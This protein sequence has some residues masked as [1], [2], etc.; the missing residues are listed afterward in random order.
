MYC[1]YSIRSRPLIQVYS[2][3]RRS[4]EAHADLAI[5]D[6]LDFFQKII[7]NDKTKLLKIHFE[8]T[9]IQV[10]GILDLE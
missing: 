8:M 9:L 7:W 2:I 5:G 3:R 10:Y 4:V 1:K 6:I